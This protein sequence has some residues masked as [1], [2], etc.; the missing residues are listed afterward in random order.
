[1]NYGIQL[2]G[3]QR[4]FNNLPDQERHVIQELHRDDGVDV[5]RINQMY[6]ITTLNNFRI[7][8]L[9]TT[10]SAAVNDA[11][12]TVERLHILRD[13]RDMEAAERRK[14]LTVQHNFTGIPFL[15]V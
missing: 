1:M 14:L 11:A 7:P 4:L 13:E 3:V 15:S 6:A 8:G 2:D 12:K 5:W 9:H 10:L